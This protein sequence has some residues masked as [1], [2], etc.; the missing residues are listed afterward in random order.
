VRWQSA[1][2]RRQPAHRQPGPAVP[3]RSCRDGAA[4]LTT[5]INRGAAELAG[6]KDGR[7]RA[8]SKLAYQAGGLLA[9][10]GLPEQEATDRL[11]DAG[12]ASGLPTAT[13]RRI[14]TRALA[15]GA[16]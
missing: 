10:S 12:T 13:A 2:C 11:T 14:V 4:Y 3:A 8:L 5:V 9:W 6:M 1:G 15:N 7:Q 16:H